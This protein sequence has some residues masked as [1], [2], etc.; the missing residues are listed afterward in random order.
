M[1]TFIIN[2]NNIPVKS[3]PG[4]RLCV[5]AALLCLLGVCLPSGF[6]H[7]AF[8]QEGQK[9]IPIEIKADK[10]DYDRTN[11]VYTAV[12]HVAIEQEGIRIEADKIVFNSK[13]GE[14]AAAGNVS[15]REK[16]DVM[17]AD[18]IDFNLN[19]RSGV[20]YNGEMF[21]GRDNYHL[22]GEKIER[23]SDTIY[24]VQNGTF[25]TCDEGEWYLKASE[26]NVDMD[27]YATG[28][29]VS[30]NMTGLP[31]LYV[32]YLLFPVRR[33]SGLLI[34]EAGYSSSEGFLMKN[35]VFW[36]ISDY[37]DMTLYSDY[38]A[39]KGHGTGIEY[40]YV[41]SSESSGQVYYNYFDTLDS[42]D[43]RWELRFQHLEEFADDLS[44]RADVN[45]VSDE[46]YYR[47]L[48]KKLELRSRP[49]IDSNAYY[50]ER[51]DTASLY[52][53]GQHS[54]DLTQPNKNTI[55]RLPEIRYTIFE[56]KIGGPLR[57]DFEGSAVNFSVDEGE[58]L[59]RADFNPGLTTS[60]GGGGVS[61]VP[62]AG[63][64]FTYYDRGVDSIEPTE[65]KYYYAGADMSARLSRVFGEDSGS[66]IGRVRHS[67]EPVI[68]YDFVPRVEQGNI[69]QFD[70]IDAVA[71]RNLITVS[72][73]NRLT[74]E[75][76]E[77]AGRK[78]FDIMVLRIS[79][80][81]DM[82]E[83]RNTDA[84]TTYP[85]SEVKGE[86][87]IKTPKLLSL[88][89]TGNYN[90]Y[91]DSM[92][93]SSESVAINAEA[94]QLDLTHRYLRD[95]QTEFLVGGL[96]FKLGRWNLGARL[97]HDMENRETSQEEY[98]A[99]Y[100]SQCWGMGL[101]YVAKPGEVQYMLTLEL[102]GLGAVKF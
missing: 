57:L 87:F 56:E 70:T 9:K 60:V 59:R 4:D 58:G 49:Y 67:I 79:Q 91:A 29:G 72:M 20:I 81:Y 7:D 25:T 43:N 53:M 54:V 74:A 100:S 15:V 34:P 38:R 62:R 89:A 8:G 71:Q 51:W 41:N 39:D 33:Q 88:S 12:G 97:W 24:R 27:R 76:R 22:K 36:A 16:G 6:A 23:R 17:R 45:L 48:E 77:G 82:N 19:A 92:T 18:R 73:I 85:R 93:S 10:L 3:R 98:R 84:A 44:G 47:D 31:V 61:L 26:I 14:A 46:L 1:T 35:S 66:G 63:A 90:P 21:L 83:V 65:R 50:V 99:L 94:V 2:I 5:K 30:F 68:S 13:T 55:Q 95:P 96:S 102:K 78:T 80:S 75:Y 40:R 101:S 69:P 42:T 64:H 32:P 86:I 52:L 37:K 28:S 11:D